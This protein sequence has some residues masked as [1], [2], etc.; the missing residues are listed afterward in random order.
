M[1]GCNS[2]KRNR[3]FTLIEIIISISIL[4]LTFGLMTLKYNKDSIVLENTANELTSAIRYAKQLN[5]A[6]NTGASFSIFR[7]QKGYYYTVKKTKNSSDIVVEG[8]IDSAVIL[9]Q[10][11]VPENY[12]PDK[13][14]TG[15]GTN[16]RELEI[17][18]SGSGASGTSILI[19]GKNTR[20][21]YKITVIPTSARIHL[22]KYK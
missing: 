10:K 15:Y 11:T 5:E 22:Y 17:K 12:Q 2:T 16:L 19:K 20:N 7:D 6:G 9:F 21:Q 3:G 4:L 14:D 8:R 13:E 18:F 1:E